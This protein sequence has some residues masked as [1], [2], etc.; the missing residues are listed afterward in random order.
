M[1]TVHELPV[2]S[3]LHPVKV[4]CWPALEV[5][6]AVS[7]TCVPCVNVVLQVPPAALPSVIVQ[8]IPA[9]L[10][11]TTPSPSPPPETVSEKEPGASNCAVTLRG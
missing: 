7:V 9:G 5:G 4:L 6:E 3:P 1:V 10:D 11:V 8:S 2:Q